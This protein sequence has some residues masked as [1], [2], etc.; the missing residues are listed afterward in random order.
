[1]IVQGGEAAAHKNW[2]RWLLVMWLLVAAILVYWRWPQINYFV[3][4]DTDD[5]LRMAQVRAWMAGQGWYDLRQYRLDP[6]GG[7]NIHWSRFVDLPIAGLIL[8]LRPIFGGLVAEKAAITIAPMLP[9][10]LAMGSAALTARRLYAPWV[11]IAGAG[12]TL[13]AAN[14]LVMFVPTRIDHHGWQLALLTLAVAG[15]TDPKSSRGGLTVGLATALSL[16]IGLEM[17]PYLAIAGA[18]LVLRWIVDANEVARL[19]AYGIALGGGTAIGFLGFASN[20][21]WAARCDALTP[22]WLTIMMMAGAALFAISFQ[23]TRSPIA[24]LSLAAALGVMLVA[25]LAWFWPQCLSRPEGVSPELE[26]LWMSQVREV[27]PAYQ[28]E[29]GSALLIISLPVMGLIGSLVMSWRAWKEGR[30][31]IW[32]P[33]LLL[34]LMSTLMVMWQTRAGPAAQLLAVP[35]FAGLAYLLLPRTLAS[36]LMLVRVFGTVAVALLVTGSFNYLIIGQIP[37]PKPTARS[38]LISRANARCPTLYSMRP[39]AQLPAATIFTFVD[40]S[41]RLI[42]VTHHRAISGPYHRNGDAILDVHHAFDGSAD[43]AEKI[44]RKHKSDL[45]LICPNMSES[46]LYAS[47]SPKGFYVQLSKGQVPDWLEPTALPKDS[48]FKLWR[49]KPE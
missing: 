41:P 26:K 1:M 28:Q 39:I 4:G 2:W 32:A 38:K 43:Q 23:R 36:K 11:W 40:L 14:A 9:L 45:L 24:R 17:L 19:R 6:P 35:G 8:L 13:T 42:T 7:A 46:T 21:N 29:L 25:V 12:I 31:A 22:V 47:R 44:V 33:I 15:L 27:K 16:V 3:L 49:V 34:S 18:G 10:L 5:N 48:P 30:L 37:E 20:D